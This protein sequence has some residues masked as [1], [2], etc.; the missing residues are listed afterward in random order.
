MMLPW[1]VG[2]KKCPLPFAVHRFAMPE[3]CD[4][5]AQSLEEKLSD[6]SLSEGTAEEYWNHLRSCITSSAEE[7]IG[8]GV[9]SNLEWFE[10]RVNVLKPLIEEKNQAH[11]RYLQVVTKSRKETFSVWCRSLLLRQKGS[12]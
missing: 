12:G 1:T 9:R 10:E 2:V 6:C 3:M 5:Y 4:A 11:Q 7:S 8:R